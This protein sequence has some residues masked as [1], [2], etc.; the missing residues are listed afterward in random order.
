MR[1]QHVVVEALVPD[2]TPPTDAHPEHPIYLPTPT[3]PEGIWGGAPLPT[4]TPPIYYPTPP[5]GIWGD[6]EHP[7]QGLPG[8][9]PGPEHPIYIPVPPPPDSGLSPEH[10]IY[11]PIPQ[12]PTGIWGDIEL[13][14]HPIVIPEPPNRDEVKQKLVDF[15]TGNLPPSSLPPLP[16]TR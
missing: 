9:Q 2:A 8:P 7:D 13:P 15:L 1:K 6:V 5:L 16:D 10:P 12:P 3:P 14:E 4:P 11:I